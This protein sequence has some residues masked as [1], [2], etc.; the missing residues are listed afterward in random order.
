M[1]NDEIK[2]PYEWGSVLVDCRNSP[3]TLGRGAGIF[4]TCFPKKFLF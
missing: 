2:K 1:T 3:Y 4:A